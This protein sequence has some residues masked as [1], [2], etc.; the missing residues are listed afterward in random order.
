MDRTESSRAAAAEAFAAVIRSL[1]LLQSSRWVD[2][3]LSMA[4][5]KT[6]M[7]V[8]STGGLSGRELAARLN[9]G[10]SAV[11]PLVDGLV[12][13]GYVR[14]EEDPADR[15]VCWA[16]PTAAG[17]ALFEQVNLASTE[18]LAQVLAKLTDDELAVVERGLALLRRGTEERVAEQTAATRTPAGVAR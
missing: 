7:L 18:E 17:T 1:R 9:I 13:H 2:L 3:D 14:R 16:R 5:F 15:R 6:A 11:T 12:R 4:Q 10:P 8:A